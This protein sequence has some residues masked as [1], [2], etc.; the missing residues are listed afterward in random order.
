MQL[1][2]KWIADWEMRGPDDR[3]PKSSI[4]IDK[5]SA[6]HLSG[7]DEALSEFIIVAY[8]KEMSRRVFAVLAAGPLEDLLVYFGAQYVDC[9]ESIARKDPKFRQLLGGIWKNAI[10]DEVWERISRVRGGTW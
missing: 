4:S 3:R 7:E 2:E 5:V 1:A 6:F 9:V 10:S 8:P